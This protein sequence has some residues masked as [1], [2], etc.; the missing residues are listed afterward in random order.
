MPYLL[1]NFD[2][3]TESLTLIAGNSRS[4]AAA[5]L[6]EAVHAGGGLLGDARACPPR[7]RVNRLR[8]ARRA[9]GPQGVEDDP[10]LVRSSSVAAGTDAG[11]LELDALV[12]EEGGVA[13]VVDDH[14]RPVEALGRPV[15]QRSVQPPVLLEGLALPGEHRS[16]GGGVD[17]AR[18]ADDDR[19]G[20]LVLR[21]EDVAGHPAHL[22][23]QRDERLDEHR[24][25]HGHV[26]RA[27]DAR[28]LQRL[29]RAELAAQRH[30]AGHL[31]LGQAQSGAGRPRRAR[32]PRPRTRTLQRA[33]GVRTWKA[34]RREC[35][36]AS[37]YSPTPLRRGGSRAARRP[38]PWAPSRRSVW[39]AQEVVRVR[40]CAPGAERAEGAA[41]WSP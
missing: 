37:A 40:V 6:V 29:R 1:S 9:T 3:V 17:R 34:R 26:Q 15:E 12:H 32:G 24:G 4:P 31:V 18:R 19:G 22:G 11:G 30:Q 16:A 33:P 27:G 2:F 28:A 14:V 7:I 39:M 8:V 21:G 41:I 25:L 35:G 13:A 36:S 10:V 20:G 38:S 23:A 5:Q